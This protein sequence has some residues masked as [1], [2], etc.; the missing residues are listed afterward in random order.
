MYHQDRDKKKNRFTCVSVEKRHVSFC[1]PSFCSNRFSL[2]SFVSSWTGGVSCGYGYIRKSNQKV[3]HEP[4]ESRSFTRFIGP[5]IQNGFVSELHKE[6]CTN[7][8]D[9]VQKPI[10]TGQ[11]LAHLRSKSWKTL[12]TFIC[13]SSLSQAD[14]ILVSLPCPFERRTECVI[15]DKCWKGYDSKFV[16]K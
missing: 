6:L 9:L 8:E 2:E 5:K 10:T 13:C 12:A 4:Q 1:F 15:C 11:L 3:G 7:G 16:P 14:A